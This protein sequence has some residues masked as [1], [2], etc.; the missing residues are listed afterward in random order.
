MSENEIPSTRQA[1][2]LLRNMGEMMV[3]MESDAAKE[4]G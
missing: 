3:N 1:S 4:K 2:T